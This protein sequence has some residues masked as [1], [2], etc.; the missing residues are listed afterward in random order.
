MALEKYLVLPHNS[1]IT[2]NNLSP[3][4][5]EPDLNQLVLVFLLC[6]AHFT[7]KKS[8]FNGVMAAKYKVKCI[9]RTYL[10]F[11]KL[12]L[13]LKCDLIGAILGKKQPKKIVF[14]GRM[15]CPRIA[16]AT[17]LLKLKISVNWS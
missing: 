5:K 9:P 4:K 16:R 17:F 15:L 3:L 12:R 1:P 7:Q 6:L 10:S 8:Y 14:K 13:T 11:A 2:D